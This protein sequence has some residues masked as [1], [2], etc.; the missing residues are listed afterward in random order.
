MIDVV[1]VTKTYGRGAQAARALDGIDLRIAPREFVSLMG[2]SGSGKSTLLNVIAGLDV[3]DEGRVVVEGHDLGA[4]SDRALA[5]FR[6]RRLGFV[7]QSFNLIPAFTV[8]KNVA[9]PLAYSGYRRAEVEERTRRA[10]ERVGVTGRERRYP[11][12]LSGGE[13]QRVA[14]ARAVATAPALLLADEPTG[15]LDSHNGRMILDLLRELNESD[16][17]TILM[18][19]HN[20]AFAATYGHRTLDLRD[21]RLVH[22]VSTTPGAPPPIRAA[23]RAPQRGTPA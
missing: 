14:V 15:N 2:P 18:V 11:A 7:F 12:E 1:G 22:D 8:E 13:L 17:L 5:N 16:G 9:W 3:P 4:L 20:V 19:T 10:L 23:G 21:G 6:L